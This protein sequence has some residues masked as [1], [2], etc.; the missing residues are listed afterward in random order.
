VREGEAA[1]RDRQPK[2]LFHHAARRAAAEEEGFEPTVPLRVRRFSKCQA[3][4]GVEDNE[5]H[6]KATGAIEVVLLVYSRPTRAGSWEVNHE[7]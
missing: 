3:T 1:G 2:S 5:R 7:G 6:V 4:G